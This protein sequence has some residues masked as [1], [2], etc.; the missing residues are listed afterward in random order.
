MP[1]LE[2][3]SGN[4][5][6]LPFLYRSGTITNATLVYRLGLE[7]DVMVMPPDYADESLMKALAQKGLYVGRDGSIVISGDFV[8]D[9]QERKT[10]VLDHCHGHQF[11]R[12][13]GACFHANKW[14]IA[15]VFQTNCEDHR[16]A[17]DLLLLQSPMMTTPYGRTQLRVGPV[18]KLLGRALLNFRQKRRM[19]V[20]AEV[21]RWVPVQAAELL[22]MMGPF[23][24]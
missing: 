13:H 2:S 15:P 12:F 10:Y 18:A 9:V 6:V 1:P 11:L 7:E 19:Q 14:S 24:D 17:H 16:F 21:A 3:E 23:L 4:H 20:V 22:Q 5:A 8:Y